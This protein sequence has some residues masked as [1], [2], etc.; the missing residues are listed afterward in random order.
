MKI[1]SKCKIE[2][3]LSEF[4]KNKRNKDGLH[5]SCKDCSK[6]YYNKNKEYISNRSKKH[7]QNN[8]DKK[9]EYHIKNKD[10]HLLYLKQYHHKHKEKAI[11]T[12]R[13]YY[14]D[15]R[16]DILEQKKIYNKNNR[17]SKRN[18]NKK[19]GQE[20]AV[21]IYIQKKEYAHEHKVERDEWY[22]KYKQT[23]RGRAVIITKSSKRRA[24][25]RNVDDGTVTADFLQQLANDTKYCIF[26]GVELI[27]ENRH[28]DHIL[29][30]SRGGLHT[31][32]NVRFI[33]N[34]ANVVKNN[35]TDEEFE[36]WLCK[37]YIAEAS[38][39]HNEIMKAS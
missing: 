20:N 14:R 17:D 39:I 15:N 22:E 1:C 37:K 31:I 33:S 2:K 10:K 38:V 6:D 16:S 26:T 18:Y 35:K 13:K 25:R 4:T 28:L 21:K 3:E 32:T 19:Y 30:L 9:K 23:D 29:P 24:I 27:P 12:S 5:N 7:Y 36:I 34:H 11:E 8:K